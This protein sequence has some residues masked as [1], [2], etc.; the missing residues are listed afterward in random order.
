MNPND[1][2]QP[3]SQPYGPSQPDNQVYRSDPQPVQARPVVQLTQDQ[4]FVRQ[5]IKDPDAVKHPR[6]RS[7]AWQHAFNFLSV[8]QLLGVA[9]LLAFLIN[10]FVFQSYQ[11]FGESMSPTLHEGDRL[12]ISKLGKTFS[13][14]DF[15]PKRGEIVFFDSTVNPAEQ[16]VKRVV[17]IPGDRVVVN[18]GEIRIY[19]IDNTNGFN[20]DELVDADFAKPTLGNVDVTVGDGE[21][22]VVGD[23]RLPDA[24][25]DS[26]FAVGLVP[27]ESVSGTL[28]MRIFPLSK[29]HSTRLY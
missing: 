14:D 1:P 22:F 24:S 19:N 25:L 20:P 16:L 2:N 29:H 21:I 13:R 4:Q 11:V 7:R 3:D 18:N 17:G 28:V 9:L 6:F 26:R 15:I 23:N 5:Q 27:I 8:L 10:Q 12:I